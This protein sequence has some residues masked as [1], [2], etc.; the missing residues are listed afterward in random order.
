MNTFAHTSN[1]ALVKTAIKAEDAAVAAAG[2]APLVGLVGQ[3]KLVTNPWEGGRTS[4]TWKKFEKSLKPGDVILTTEK[5]IRNPWKALQTPMSGTP[6]YHAELYAGRGRTTGV[7]EGAR[8]VTTKAR[9]V[10]M[11]NWLQGYNAV[12]LRLKGTTSKQRSAVVRASKRIAERPGREYGT[13][14]AVKAWAKDIFVPKVR[15]VDRKTKGVPR[16][17]GPICSTTASR[18]LHRVTG[19]NVA[20]KKPGDVLP[21]DFLRDKRF[22]VVGRRIRGT[23]GKQLTDRLLSLKGVPVA[24]RIGMGALLAGGAYATQKAFKAV[25]S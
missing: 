22:K 6:F 5:G 1:M 4:R 10:S 21:A 12:A 9:S 17:V 13:G 8:G 2:A 19:I 20:G 11:K 18:P 24:A 15:R 7:V 25:T 23:G 3:K 14:Q 16:C